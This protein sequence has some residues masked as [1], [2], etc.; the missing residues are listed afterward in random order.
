MKEGEDRQKDIA[1]AKDAF[2]KPAKLDAEAAA[3]IQKANEEAWAT[4]PLNEHD[5]L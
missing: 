3:D 1:A 5:G 2:A 4:L